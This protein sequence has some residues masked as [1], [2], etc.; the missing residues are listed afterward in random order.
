M[1]LINLREI[2][3]DCLL[4][5]WHITEP[6]ED[7]DFSFLGKDK[8]LSSISISSR[9]MASIAARMLVKQMLFHWKTPYRGLN[10]NEDGAPILIDCDFKVSLSHSGE[11]AMALLHKHKKVGI[12]IELVREKILKI[13]HRVFSAGELVT[14]GNDVEKLTVLWCAK[15]A[16]YKMYAD[17]K[18][19]FRDN[20]FIGPFEMKNKGEMHGEIK[21]NGKD[22]VYVIKYEKFSGYLMAYTC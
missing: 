6:L 13:S 11:Y 22:T 20:I 17:K 10:K 8:Y 4:G 7:P 18:L 19:S 15:E 21:I 5:R 9:K 16:L 1:P 3:N 2:G 12:D 14:A